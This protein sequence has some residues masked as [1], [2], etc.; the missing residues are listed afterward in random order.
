M[1]QSLLPGRKKPETPETEQEDNNSLLSRAFSSSTTTKRNSGVP[2]AVYRD[3]YA[4]LRRSLIRVSLTFILPALSL[5]LIGFVVFN[6]VISNQVE[7]PT[8]AESVTLTNVPLPANVRRTADTA[9]ELNRLGSTYKNLASS[10]L[11]TYNMRLIKAERYEAIGR[12]G[13][14]IYG[15][16]K[17]KLIDTKQW[18]V[19]NQAI[20]VNSLE[21]LLVRDLTNGER[22]TLLLEVQTG[23]DKDLNK[24]SNPD[25]GGTVFALA[26]L[27]GARR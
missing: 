12:T 22:E 13:A 23:A 27:V 11:P 4:R 6:V 25:G 10:W 8:T 26:K 7:A 15:Y 19:Q 24:P 14:Q 2:V 16:Y 17:T 3:P 20:L 18:R 1:F 5:L 21:V 9:A